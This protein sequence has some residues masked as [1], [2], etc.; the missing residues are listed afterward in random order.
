MEN[1][2]RKPMH[3]WNNK[4]NV[5]LEAKKYFSRSQFAKN[6]S[7]AHASS[8]RN[9]WFE[10]ACLNMELQGSIYKRWIYKVSFLDGSVYIGL[11]CNFKQRKSSHLTSK[12]SSVYQY[13]VKTKT[14]PTFKIISDLLD[15]KE[16]SELEAKL[17]NEYINLGF[18]V[19]NRHKGGGL[20]SAKI[21][22]TFEICKAE[23]IKYNTRNEFYIKSKG[24]YCASWNN[25]WLNA[26]C[27]HMSIKRPSRIKHTF[28]TCKEVAKKYHSRKEFSIKD[29]S[30]YQVSA[31][32]KWLDD[33]CK[34]MI[35]KRLLMGSLTYEKCKEN[36]SKCTSRSD[37]TKKYQTSYN[38]SREKEWLND[39]FPKKT[40]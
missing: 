6:S 14:I 2:D 39:F 27:E 36:A 29:K 11:T 33:I 31:K 17:I 4:E 7:G 15:K 12:K 3:Y 25:K 24:A 40:N 18:N 5:L 10:E 26:V 21:F 34:H 35:S 23:A 32:N 16:A 20:G 19:L 38:K 28:E 30:A 8:V 13:I 37:F 22:Y 9:K 1:K